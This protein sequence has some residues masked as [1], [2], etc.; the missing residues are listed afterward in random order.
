[1]KNSKCVFFLGL[2]FLSCALNAGAAVGAIGDYVQDTVRAE[3]LNDLYDPLLG[4]HFDGS[5]VYEKG[6]FSS[7]TWTGNTVTETEAGLL[8][9]G[10]YENLHSLLCYKNLSLQNPSHNMKEQIVIDSSKLSYYE[11]GAH[12]NCSTSLQLTIPKNSV[13]YRIYTD[14]I[15]MK[16]ISKDTSANGCVG[17]EC[18]IDF[19]YRGKILFLGEEYFVR[20]VVGNDKIYIDKGMVFDNISN[21]GYSA[22]YKGYKFKVEH[23]ISSSSYGC[24]GIL[25]DVQRPDGS[26]VQVQASGYANGVVDGL[27]IMGVDWETAGSLEEASIIVYDL[28]TEIL[29]QDGE[30]LEIGGDFMTDWQ[31]MFDTADNCIDD[32]NCSIGEY[33]AMDSY[34][35]DSLLRSITISYNHDLDGVEALGVNETLVFPGSFRLRFRG[36]LHQNFRDVSCPA[37]GPVYASYFIGTKEP[38]MPLATTTTT[39]TTTTTS[40]TTTQPSCGAVDYSAN[41]YYVQD[42]YIGENPANLY[43]SSAGLHF[44]GSYE[45][46]HGDFTSYRW[47]GRNM[48]ESMSDLLLEESNANVQSLLCFQGHSLENPMHDMDERIIVNSSRISYY[49]PGAHSNCSTSLQLRVPADTVSYAIYADYLPLKRISVDTASH[50]CSGDDCVLDFEYRGKIPFLGEEYYIKDIIGEKMWLDKGMVIDN[51][52]NSGYVTAYKGYKFRVDHIISSGNCSAI[53]LDVQKPGGVIVQVQLTGLANGVVDDL[54]I[55]GIAWQQGGSWQEAS[56]IVYDTSTEAVLENGQYLQVAG[57]VKTGWRVQYVTV[58]SCVYSDYASDGSWNDCGISEYD[59]MD[60]ASTHSLLKNI[61]ITYDR[62]ISGSTSLGINDSLILPDNLKLRFRG[63]LNNKYREVSCPNHEMVYATYFLGTSEQAV[64]STTT[65]TI[66]S[67]TTSTTVAG[68]TLP[69]DSPPCGV[70]SLGEVINYINQWVSGSASLSGVINLIN[71]WASG[72]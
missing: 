72:A 63:Y 70:I 10:I 61:L 34:S 53:V 40:T 1:M 50:G 27:E 17:E 19:E 20:D 49:E 23:I 56:I 21:A 55:V 31:I 60:E 59:G 15:P 43:T 9:E 46:W 35:T 5:Y 13:S 71:A 65:S 66:A 7:Y 64:S 41:G 54:E 8:S 48:T 39:T 32:A 37:V 18:Y 68:C 67:T 11:P 33:D 12:S 52:S 57:Q 69:G 38:G 36:Y 44:D 28:S 6:D 51:V 62:D 58:D 26:V 14:Y 25:I 16:R 4:L 2:F 30:D 24:T 45:F 47:C 42:V 29:L 22:P 3:N